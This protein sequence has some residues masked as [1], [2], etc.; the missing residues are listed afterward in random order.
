MSRAFILEGIKNHI[1]SDKSDEIR[2]KEVVDRIAQHSRGILPASPNTRIKK[3]NKFIEKVEASQ[4]SIERVSKR[5]LA[6]SISEWVRDHNLPNAIRMGSDER[7][8]PI[9]EQNKNMLE[10]KDGPSDGQDL[11]S[12]SHGEGGVVETGTLALFS[13]KDNPT[14]L[15][16]LPENHIV[17]LNESSIVDHYED[18]WSLVRERFGEGVMPRNL[19]FITGPSRSADIEQTL[20]LGA[21]GPI[22]LH[23]LLLRE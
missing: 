20:L 4:A 6:K 11:V 3:V 14:T 19:N 23:V 21:H 12:V 10:I 5:H 9:R 18:I 8:A 7:L 13:G 15:N 17:V 22:R 2:R 16:F 1:S